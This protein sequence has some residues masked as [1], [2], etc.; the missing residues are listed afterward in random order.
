[1]EIPISTAILA[2]NT[3]PNGKGLVTIVRHP[4]KARILLLFP[5]AVGACHSWWPLLSV[6]EQLREFIRV[7]SEIVRRDG[8]DVLDV[9]GKFL[10]I[11]EY[12]DLFR[13]PG[14]QR[15]TAEAE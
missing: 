10:R 11:P 5:Y 2:W 15:R 9:Q 7:G 3:Q 4:D 13:L 12:R 14:T 8:V 1:M 6:R